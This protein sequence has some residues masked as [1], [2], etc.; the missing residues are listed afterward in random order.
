MANVHNVILRGLNAIYRQ[1]P[2]VSQQK[3]IADFMLYIHAW[4]DM[5]HHHHLLEET[6]FFPRVEELAREAGLPESL[7]KPNLDQHHIFEPKM[8]EMAEWASE[9]REGK[10]E[11]ESADLIKL[12]D[13]FAPILTQHL[14]EEIDTLTKLEKCDGEGIR[15]ALKLAAEAGHKDA[16]RVSLLI[17]PLYNDL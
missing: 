13:G 14:H 4:A 1:A 8:A 10:R 9:V 12:I 7:M 11:Y 5:V 3:D 16:D 6:I 15:K 2:H 17:S